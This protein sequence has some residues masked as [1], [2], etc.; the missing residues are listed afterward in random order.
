MP[1]SCWQKTILTVLL[2]ARIWHLNIKCTTDAKE[3]CPIVLAHTLCD[4]ASHKPGDT[5]VV[6][7]RATLAVE[8]GCLF[9]F[10]Y[11]KI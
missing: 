7:M 3:P 2:L 5:I 4:M 9:N 6:L 11:H 10:V 8:K 1:S